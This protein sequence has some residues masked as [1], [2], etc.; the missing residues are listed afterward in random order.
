M[1]FFPQLFHALNYNGRIRFISVKFNSNQQVLYK[2]VTNL[3]HDINFRSVVV[4]AT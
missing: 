4:S 2:S 3:V 1:Q